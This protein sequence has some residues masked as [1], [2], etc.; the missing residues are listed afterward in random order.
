MDLTSSC[1]AVLP[2]VVELDKKD[3]DSPFAS[4]DPLL[5][6]ALQN[7]RHRITVLRMEL[8]IQQFIQN[9]DLHHFEFPQFPTS[10]LKR[11]AH[12]V[13][14]HY[15]LQTSS[16]EKLN[17]YNCFKSTVIAKK[18]S[19]IRFPPI[20]LSQIPPVKTERN[21][22]KK[23]VI[24]S[25]RENVGV[26]RSGGMERIERTEM[27]RKEDYEKARA[28]IFDG[29]NGEEQEKCGTG[30]DQVG[31]EKAVTVT[32]GENSSGSNNGGGNRV[33]IFKDHFKDRTDPDF[34]RRRNFAVGP[35][36]GV[37]PHVLQYGPI[38]PYTMMPPNLE[39]N[40]AYNHNS[41]FVQ[42]RCPIYFTLEGMA[43]P[44]YQQPLRY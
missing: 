41:N 30:E 19:E 40:Y 23:I 17:K 8:D 11:C 20:G 42:Y 38:S 12:R 5:V 10:F 24:L 29:K 15:G 4:V 22:E 21:R 6:Q 18:S 36:I 34:D 35:Q 31:R 27:E 25:R 1:S 28:R 44:Q 37:Q 2:L 3:A 13:A 9:P 26:K 14:Q 43:Y 7:P 33:A 39:F 32:A 16:S